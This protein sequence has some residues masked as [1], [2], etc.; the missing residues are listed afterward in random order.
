MK[1][2]TGR[3]KSGRAR[4][5]WDALVRMGFEPASLWYNANNWGQSPESG[6]G[7]WAFSGRIESWCGEDQHGVYVQRSSGPFVKTYEKAD[8]KPL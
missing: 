5:I 8:A 2:H 3:P 1:I 7:T 4:R 6:W